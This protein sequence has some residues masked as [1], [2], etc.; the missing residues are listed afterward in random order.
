MKFLFSLTVA[1]ILWHVMGL[2]KLAMEMPAV[3]HTLGAVLG[4]VK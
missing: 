3:W 2:D 1:A 4:G